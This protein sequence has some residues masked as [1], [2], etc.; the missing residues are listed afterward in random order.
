MLQTAFVLLCVVNP[1]TIFAAY[2]AAKSALGGVMSEVQSAVD[3][4]TNQLVKAQA[5]IVSEINNLEAAVAAGEPVNLDALKA[6]AQA[7]DDVVADAPAAEE[8]PADEA[9]ADQA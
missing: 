8:A 5:E 2:L 7:L 1:L 6:A 9:P 4:V 3:A